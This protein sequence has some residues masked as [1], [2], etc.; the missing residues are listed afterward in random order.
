MHLPSTQRPLPQ[1][2]ISDFLPPQRMYAEYSAYYAAPPP[3]PFGLGLGQK[4]AW[5]PF[6]TYSNSGVPTSIINPP[7]AQ[8]P[9]R[10]SRRNSDPTAGYSPPP[11]ASAIQVVVPPQRSSSHN[12]RVHFAE[13]QVSPEPPRHHSRRH[14]TGRTFAEYFDSYKEREHSARR[15]RRSSRSSRSTQDGSSTSIPVVQ[16]ITPPALERSH[17]YG[18]PL[19]PIAQPVNIEVNPASRSGERRKS[20]RSGAG[21]TNAIGG[22]DM[23]LDIHL[24][25]RTLPQLQFLSLLTSRNLARREEAVV[26]LAAARGCMS[27]RSINP[28]SSRPVVIARID[29]PHLGSPRQCLRHLFHTA[30]IHLPLHLLIRGPWRACITLEVRRPCRCL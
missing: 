18:Y 25:H 23:I 13:D 15:R 3:A 28:P 22:G 29:I 1:Y 27:T 10:S 24:Y 6:E 2:T 7:S 4:Y 11:P 5:A 16:T 14:S 17:R 21:N 30:T 8:S 26:A 9:R 12:K 19:P 20:S